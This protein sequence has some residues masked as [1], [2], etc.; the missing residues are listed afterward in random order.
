M[1]WVIAS[2]VLLVLSFVSSAAGQSLQA[3]GSE[4]AIGA[5]GTG[6]QCRVRVTQDDASRG[7]TRLS[8]LCDGWRV[9]SGA[10]LRFRVARDATPERLLTDS[11]FQKSYDTRLAGCG[12]VEKTT[13][14]DGSPAAIR[15]CIRTDGGWPMVV[16]AAIA[17]GRGFALETFPTN[18]R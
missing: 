5:N 1:T 18:V 4:A 12:T 8:V 9:P 16:I 7:L 15:Q 3:V 17:G 11:A 10:L 14:G 13:L 2:T 6:E